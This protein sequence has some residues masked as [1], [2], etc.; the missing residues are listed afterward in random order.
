MKK[1]ECTPGNTIPQS[2]FIQTAVKRGLPTCLV[3]CEG[4]GGMQRIQIPKKSKAPLQNVDLIQNSRNFI[5]P[6]FKVNSL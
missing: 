4:F 1:K 6:Q 5:L 2:V 3:L